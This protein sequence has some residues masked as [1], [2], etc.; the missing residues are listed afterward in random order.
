MD[1]PNR[2]AKDLPDIRSL[3]LRY[4]EDS[5]LVFGDEVLDANLPDF[6]LAPAYLMGMHLRALCTEEEAGPVLRFFEAMSERKPA[7]MTFVRAR[8]FGDEPENEARAQLKA[9]H[10]GFDLVS[11]S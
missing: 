7:W 5:D 11:I 9:F 2:R 10:D 4:K 8:A 3:L 6:S 1:D